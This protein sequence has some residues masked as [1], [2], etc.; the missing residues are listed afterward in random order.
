MVDLVHPGNFWPEPCR[1]LGVADAMTVQLY[2]SDARR[3]NC[4][5]TP[6]FEG[7]HG[8]SCLDTLHVRALSGFP[9]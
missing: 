3:Y 9:V 8:I 6:L 7:T 5:Q 4:K 2:V 1:Q